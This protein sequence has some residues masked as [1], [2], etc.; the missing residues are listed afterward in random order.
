MRTAKHLAL[1]HLQTVDVALDGAVAPGQ[2]E[3]RGDSGQVL[4]QPAGEA[5]QRVD[6]TVGGRCDPGLQ[7]TAPVVAV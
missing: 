4:L 6:A 3:P 1:Q 5:G 7:V 2:S